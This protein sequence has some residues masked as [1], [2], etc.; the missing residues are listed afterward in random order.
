[1]NIRF[2]ANLIRLARKPEVKKPDIG[3]LGPEVIIEL[4]K[5]PGGPHE[6]KSK[7]REEK[8]LKKDLKQ[9]NFDNL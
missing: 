6:N 2:I 7:K 5:R 8:K 9:Q 3:A 4:H 1:M